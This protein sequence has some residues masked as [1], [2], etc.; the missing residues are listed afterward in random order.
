MADSAFEIAWSLAVLDVVK[1]AIALSFNGLYVSLV[2]F[3]MYFLRRRRPVGQWVFICAIATMFILAMTQISLQ[4]ATTTISLQSVYSAVNSDGTYTAHWDS[5]QR[6]DSILGFVE[7]FLLVTNATIIE[8]LLIYRCYVIW[9]THHNKKQVLLLPL[10]LLLCNTVLGYITVSRND[11]LPPQYHMDTRIVV[12]ST[13]LNNVLVT[14]LTVGR[15]WW[16]RRHLQTIGQTKFIQR[17]N[18]AMAMLLESSAVYCIGMCMLV[19][20]LSIGSSNARTGFPVAYV[21][22]GFAGQLVNII[23]ALIV[24]RLGIGR[25]TEMNSMPA[26]SKPSMV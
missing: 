12:G 15:I 10:L 22:Y 19:V 7:D 17:Y 25:K 6:M 4:I 13:I 14:G 1:T 3:A 26:Q 9:G 5:L 8:G 20:A 11:L 16:T 21:I 2:I 24:V 23:P 18:T